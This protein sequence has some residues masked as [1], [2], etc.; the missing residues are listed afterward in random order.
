MSLAFSPK[1]IGVVIKVAERCN[2]ACPYC[3]FFYKNDQSYKEHPP[4]ISKSVINGTRDFIKQGIKEFSLE[5]VNIIFHGGEPLLL[6]P[7]TLDYTCNVLSECASETRKIRFGLQTNSVLVNEKWIEVF[8][9]HKVGVGV[10][11]DGPKDINDV[12]RF[13]HAGRGSY[14]KALRG[15]RLL[16][17][18]HSQNRI[19]EPS[20]I[21]VVN[22]EQDSRRIYRHFVDEMQIRRL[23]YLFLDKHHEDV[24]ELDISGT[25]LYIINLIDKWVKD[26]DKNYVYVFS[27]K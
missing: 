24:T 25:K 18:A 19:P 10:S 13:D 27:Q 26:S 22:P 20:L 3:Y 21:C 16:Q 12:N 2:L 8:E 17:E 5:S 9:R 23:H 1:H 15:L 6:H 11:F 14:D 7:E 4:L